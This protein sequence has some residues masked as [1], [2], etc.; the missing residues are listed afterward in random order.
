LEALKQLLNH[1]NFTFTGGFEIY[2][3]AFLGDGN[4]N[5]ENSANIVGEIAVD[6]NHIR[7]VADIVAYVN[8]ATLD[9]P[10]NPLVLMLGENGAVL[11]W[12]NDPANLVPFIP[13]VTLGATQRVEIYN[14]L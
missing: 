3:E 6:P 1:L 2:Q 10:S 7:Q 11:P 4:M 9:D 13:L 8:F 12:N 14:N 5:S